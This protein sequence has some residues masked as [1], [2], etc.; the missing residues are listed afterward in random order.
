MLPALLLALLA[1]TPLLLR[2]SVSAQMADPDAAGAEAD[3][4]A[5]AMSPETNETL[6]RLMQRTAAVQA[7]TARGETIAE[8]PP[9]QA[10]PRTEEIFYYPCSDCHAVEVPNPKVRELEDEHTDLGFQHGGG[11]FWCYTCHNADNMDRLASFRGEL[12]SYDESYKLC[13]QCHFQRQK[14]WYFGG[15]GKRAGMFY[16]PRDAPVSHEDFDMSDRE[17]IGTWQGE[18]V[19]HNCTDCHNAHS[20]SIK[21][22]EPSPPPEPRSGLARREIEEDVHVKVWDVLAGG[23]G[24]ER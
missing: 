9:F 16:L 5:S 23:H 1:F 21:T 10:T 7:V 4:A 20:P 3:A 11:R 17:S 19:I 15:H 12:I 18:R 24:E 8:A 2:W 14:D 13:G 6:E 22:F